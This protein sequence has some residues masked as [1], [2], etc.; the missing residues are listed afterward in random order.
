MTS[1]EWL[2][3]LVAG[4]IALLLA[5]SIFVGCAGLQV[6]HGAGDSFNEPCSLAHLPSAYD[7]CPD[8]NGDIEQVE[9]DLLLVPSIEEK[10]LPDIVFHPVELPP[11]GVR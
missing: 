1:N 6:S 10:P 5:S 3:T 11:L 2:L 4:G 7:G 8:E 9:V